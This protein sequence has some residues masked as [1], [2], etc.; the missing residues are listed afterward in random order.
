MADSTSSVPT[1]A[2]SKYLANPV[3]SKTVPTAPL[4]LE[5]PM[6]DLNELL[7]GLRAEVRKGRPGKGYAG[8][9][10]R[11]EY[12]PGDGNGRPDRIRLHAGYGALA[13]AG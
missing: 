12:L 6:D 10:A 7:I 2:K 1:K 9:I 3:I 5:L 4:P 11:F 13:E 8:I